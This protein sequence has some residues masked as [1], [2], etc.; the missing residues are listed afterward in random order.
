[1]T[2]LWGAGLLLTGSATAA[3]TRTGLLRCDADL[4]AWVDRNHGRKAVE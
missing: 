4:R 3:L 2:W 1:V